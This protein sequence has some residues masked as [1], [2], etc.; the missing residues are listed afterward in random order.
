VAVLERILYYLDEAFEVAGFPDYADA[1]NGLQ[2][3]G[4]GEVTHIGAAVDGSLQTIEA[5]V[6]R[7]VDFLLVHHGLFWG[8]PGPL[9][10]P[11]LKKVAPLVKHGTS[12]YSLHLPLDADP[13]FG[14]NS[15]ILRELGLR[16]EGRFGTVKDIPIGWW[17]S[18]ACRRDKLVRDLERILGEKVRVIPGG[19]DQVERV[20]VLSGAG[21]SA[22]S[23]AA[24]I[25]LDSL[26]TGEAPHHAFHE[27][28]ELGVNLFLGGHYATETF[29]VK[30]LA[31]NL[32]ETFGVPWEFLHF[33]TGL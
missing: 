30:A 24:A 29:G 15:V 10:G 9:T 13:K 31:A 11:R 21:S 16:P 12:L 8:G 20:G 2:L 5:A 1:F 28:M 4:K 14:N 26:I 23:E 22:L 18:A 17:G 32:S 25:G 19:P 3:E 6:E 33:P 27:A 7:G